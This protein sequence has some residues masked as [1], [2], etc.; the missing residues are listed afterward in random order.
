M[1]G[2]SPGLLYGIGLTSEV[3]FVF[4]SGEKVG[5]A[6]FVGS[7]SGTAAGIP[8]SGSAEAF[9]YLV[10][11]NLAPTASGIE[12]E[13]LQLVEAAVE[14]VPGTGGSQRPVAL[15][16]YSWNEIERALGAYIRKARRSGLCRYQW[17]I[18]WEEVDSGL[19][20]GWDYGFG[21]GC[22]GFDDVN[23]NDPKIA[24]GEY[25]FFDQIPDSQH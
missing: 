9:E 12:I 11:R 14:L 10:G 22:F 1:P 24:K 25:W 13:P 19:G 16:R 4:E 3:G 21:Y 7:V 6:V 5:I 18:S 20:I 8:S 17:H 23:A 2:T 15:A